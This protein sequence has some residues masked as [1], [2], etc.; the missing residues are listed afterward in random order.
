MTIVQLLLNGLM[1]GAILAIFALS[2]NIIYAVLRYTNFAIAG[3]GTVGAYAGYVA[4]VELQLPFL[5]AAVIG[6]VVAGLIGLIAEE[7]ALRP[8]RPAG[9][10]KVAIASIAVN[11]VLE[12]LMRFIFSNQPRDFLIDLMRD[13]RFWGLRVGPQQLHNAEVAIVCAVGL[14]AALFFTSIGRSMRAVA[15]NWQLAALR[16][17]RARHVQWAAIFAG[18]GLAGLGGV[19]LAA[20]T[21]LTPLLGTSML[22]P[23]FAAA[24]LGGLGSL[25]GALIGAFLIGIAEAMSELVIDPSYRMVVS[26]LAIMLVLVSRPS[27]VLGEK[28]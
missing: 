5:A 22:L 17:I 1:E 2:F 3:F 11:I 13:Y 23:M 19:L 10:I 25:P 27:G 28:A 24:V 16:G 7:L 18:A 6:F 4:N 9:M 21:S 15:D 14:F 8:L 26:F 12:N 20:E